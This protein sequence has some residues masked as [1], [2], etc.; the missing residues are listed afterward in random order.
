MGG[1]REGKRSEGR[2]RRERRERRVRE[3]CGLE[4][5]MEN[6][7]ATSSIIKQIDGRDGG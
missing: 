1:R 7:C 6:D 5:R 3:A 2:K 4:G